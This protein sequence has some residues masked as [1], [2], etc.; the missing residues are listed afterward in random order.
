MSPSTFRDLCAQD[1]QLEEINTYD[2]QNS[3][4]IPS[5]PQSLF[6]L[7]LNRAFLL[8]MEPPNKRCIFSRPAIP[9]VNMYLLVCKRLLAQ[10]MVHLFKLGLHLFCVFTSRPGVVQEV[11]FTKDLFSNLEQ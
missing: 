6:V 7:H 11:L 8:I 4:W 1:T 2:K 5:S 3:L 9:D 10:N